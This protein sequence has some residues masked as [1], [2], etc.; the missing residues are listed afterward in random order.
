MVI[1]IDS[2]VDDIMRQW[3]ATM[4][5]FLDYRMHCVGCPIAVFHTVNDSCREHG[6]DAEAFLGAL[7]R[8][9]ALRINTEMRRTDALSARRA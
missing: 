1:E 6:V 7:R 2:V 4:R 3:P 5:V 9:A 8:Q